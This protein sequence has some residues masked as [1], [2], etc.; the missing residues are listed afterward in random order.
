MSLK[1]WEYNNKRRTQSVGQRRHAIN[2]VL[3]WV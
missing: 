2:N 3:I 1:Q